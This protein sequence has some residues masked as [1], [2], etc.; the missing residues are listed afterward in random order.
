MKRFVVL[1]LVL[2]ML[3]VGVGISLTGGSKTPKVAILYIATGRYITFWDDF[4]QSAEKN[5]LPDIPK[6]YFIWTDDVTKK[7]P[8][9]VVKIHQPQLP[10][11]GPAMK[12][13]HFFDNARSQL[14]QFD[15]LFFMNAN[16]IVDKPVGRE[17]LPTNKQRFMMTQ[18][19]GYTRVSPKNLPYDRSHSKASIQP[20]EGR[21]YVAGGFNGGKSK[22]FLKMARII[23][24]WVDQD[25]KKKI[26]PL[27]HDESYLNRFLINIEKKGIQPLILDARYLM[28]E[29]ALKRGAYQNLATLKK[30]TKI[31]ILD[32]TQKGGHE[33]LRSMPENNV[34]KK[35]F[36][37]SEYLPFFEV[38]PSAG[39]GNKMFQYATAFGYAEKHGKKLFMD[40]DN[41]LFQVFD[42]TAKKSSENPFLHSHLSKKQKK[43]TNDRLLSS[44]R[45]NKKTFVDSKYIALSGYAQ[46]PRFFEHV[47]HKIQKEFQF[48]KPLSPKNKKLA[49]QMKRENSI[50]IHVRRGDYI[51]SGYPILTLPYY[52]KAVEYI[53]SKD[54]A[55]PHIYLFSN[56]INWVKKYFK[57]PWKQTIVEGNNDIQDL[58]LMTQC[59]HNIIANS[60]YSWWGAYLNPNPDKIVVMPDK[61]DYWHDWWAKE[62]QPEKWHMMPAR[63]VIPHKVAVITSVNKKT[64]SLF[65]DFLK[66]MEERFF[67]YAPKKYYVFRSDKDLFLPKKVKAYTRSGISDGILSVISQ[68]DQLKK[69]LEQ[70]DF[71]VISNVEMRLI[72]EVLTDAFPAPRQQAS[73]LSD[74]KDSG[75]V[76]SEFFVLT[77]SAFQ[78]MMNFVSM[79]IGANQEAG[80]LSPLS[81][82][83]YLTAWKKQETTLGR[84]FLILPQTLIKRMY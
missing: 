25:E 39:L 62:I 26:I 2:V 5:F 68:L 37:I 41:Q 58:H 42:V 1:L 72:N 28:P 9:N 78:Q 71:V 55:S 3:M 12:R 40:D 45:F 84:D 74:V 60:S 67:V 64:H 22:A 24:R 10:W 70:Y 20:N 13:Y 63:D 49:D 23:K 73:F 35:E 4:Y 48:K 77:G 59:R 27:W 47:S 52:K 69:E 44:E 34:S 79:A 56:D 21:I 75:K 54:P 51:T 30:D 11:P 36:D 17:I 14:E 29:E 8:K 80:L 7:F 83:A 61:W 43:E 57:T 18:H 76:S 31:I 50:C 32:K 33:W 16:L 65:D 46:A 81:D 6:T 15:Y 66:N 19:P 82:T 53:L 38:W